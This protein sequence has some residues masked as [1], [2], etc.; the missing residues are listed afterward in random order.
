MSISAVSSHSISVE[1]VRIISGRSFA[2]VR[3]AIESNL[4]PLDGNIM[5]E[6]SSGDLEAIRR[7]EE[8][9]PKLFLFLLRDHGAL[10]AI[11]GRQRKAIQYEIGNPIIASKMT[12]HNLAAALYAPL[13][14][15]LFETAD[16][17]VVFEYD[18]PSSL[19]GQLGDDQI[20]EVALDLDRA[21]EAA[22][23]SAAGL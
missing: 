14:I 8:H 1:H 2:E 21:L 4:P 7:R 17:K 20:N 10:L 6:L 3:A 16:G 18:K 9:A 19:F 12:H 22:L 13:R 5:L 15:A 11:A 23:L